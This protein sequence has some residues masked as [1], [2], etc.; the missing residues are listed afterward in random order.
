MANA[1]EKLVAAGAPAIVEP[2]FYRISENPL[3]NY[4]ILEIREREPYRG[5]KLKI[6]KQIRPGADLAVRVAEAAQDA[7]DE[8][9]YQDELAALVGE[10]SSAT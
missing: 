3:N 10:H 4:V 2:L 6:R 9:Q 1:Y 5:S 8:I 7:Y